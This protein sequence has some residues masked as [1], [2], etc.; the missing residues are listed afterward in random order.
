MTDAAKPGVVEATL[1][2]RGLVGSLM[3][4]K[5]S[6]YTVHVVCLWLPTVDLALARVAERVRVGGHDVP[7]DARATPLLI[8]TGGRE[9]ATRVRDEVRWRLAA[10]GYLDE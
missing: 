5:A 9:T 6:G 3:G 4:V 2:S 7:A 10:A 1:A 8:A